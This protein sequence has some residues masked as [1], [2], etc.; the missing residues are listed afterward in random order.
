MQGLKAL[1]VRPLHFSEAD[2]IVR[3]NDVRKLN[4]EVSACAWQLDHALWVLRRCT[5]DTER[6]HAKEGLDA[7]R[8]SVDAKLA[9]LLA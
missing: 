6:Q 7:V 5:N 4:A 2:H 3:A 1:S 8:R 9:A